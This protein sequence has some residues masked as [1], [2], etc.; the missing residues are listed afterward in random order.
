[1]FLK[2]FSYVS[3]DLFSEF[4]RLEQ[5]WGSYL[6]KCVILTHSTTLL[7]LTVTEE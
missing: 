4:V 7:S 3:N 1:M 2:C 6:P 5:Y